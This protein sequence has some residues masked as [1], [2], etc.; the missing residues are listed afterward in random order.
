MIRIGLIGDYKTDVI[1]H[2]AIPKAL[3]LAGDPVEH[4]WLPTEELLSATLSGFSGFWCVPASPYESMEGAL[5]AIRYAREQRRP[6]LGTCGGFQHALIEYA[7][8]V[9]GFTEAD[10]AESNPD[11]SMPLMTNLVCPLVEAEGLIRFAPGSRAAQIYGALH[12]R[13]RYH[14]SFGLNPRYR[15]LF[16]ASALRFSGVDESDDI[17]VV[18][19]TGHPFFMATLFQPERSALAGHVHPLIQAFV[20]AACASPAAASA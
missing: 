10:H 12:A 6:F 14:C 13:E 3:E 11:S 7:R 15:D 17:R 4:V 20:R 9:L 18:E 16:A 19:L 5:R 8:N 1:A 2:Q